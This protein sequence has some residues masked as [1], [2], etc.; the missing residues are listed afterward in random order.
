MN[1]FFNFVPV[2]FVELP[3]LT[4]PAVHALSELR[5]AKTPATCHL[6]YSQQ[7]RG[8]CVLEAKKKREKEQVFKSSIL[9]GRGAG[10]S[11]V[12][13]IAQSTCF[14]TLVLSR[15]FSPFLSRQNKVLSLMLVFRLAGGCNGAKKARFCEQVFF[16]GGKTTVVEQIKT[17]TYGPSPRRI[18]IKI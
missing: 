2:S 1:I 6:K 16:S 3:M 17:G 4:Y 18:P 11:M 15:F 8:A 13:A 14:W 9:I 7:V 12:A 5:G 10:G